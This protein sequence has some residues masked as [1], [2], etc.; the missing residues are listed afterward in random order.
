MCPVLGEARICSPLKTAP[1]RSRSARAVPMGLVARPP[2]RDR[3][4]R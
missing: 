4:W 2:R 1:W 3:Q